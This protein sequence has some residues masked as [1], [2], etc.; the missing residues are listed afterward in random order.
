MTDRTNR[1]NSI[2]GEEW[3]GVW[4][5]GKWENFLWLGMLGEVWGKYERSGEM[6]WGVGGGKG[7]RGKMCWGCGSV[8]GCGECGMGSRCVEVC[9]RCG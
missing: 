6:C 7:R 9:L 5:V 8:L 2:N 1:H 3:E 4:M